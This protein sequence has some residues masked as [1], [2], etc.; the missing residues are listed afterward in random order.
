MYVLITLRIFASPFP[1]TS[2]IPLG[3][4]SKLIIPCL[5]SLQVVKA[6]LW[7]QPPHK[8]E[9]EEKSIFPFPQELGTQRSHTRYTRPTCSFFFSL[10]KNFVRSG[11]KMMTTVL[12][13]W[14][15]QYS[16]LTA[17]HLKL[18]KIQTDFY[19]NVCSWRKH[20][21]ILSQIKLLIVILD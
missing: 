12:E 19:F 17:S 14:F 2:R 20:A 9:A 5:L 21:Y 13:K 7:G 8:R 3:S 11:V 18:V 15:L 10:P 1:N 4:G 16:A 6:H